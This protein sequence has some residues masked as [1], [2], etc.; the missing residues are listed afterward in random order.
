MD[1]ED[2]SIKAT[3]DRIERKQEHLK[4]YEQKLRQKF[5]SM[6]KKLYQDQRHKAAGLI[7]R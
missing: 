1:L 7:C 3:D 4:A 2:A 5:A 6:E